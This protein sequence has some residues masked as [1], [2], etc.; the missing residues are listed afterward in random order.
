MKG[1]KIKQSEFRGWSFD[2]PLSEAF[3]RLGELS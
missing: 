1:A 2:E 3:M